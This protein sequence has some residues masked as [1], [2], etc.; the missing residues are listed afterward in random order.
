MLKHVC[1]LTRT[2]R[3]TVHNGKETHGAN[4]HSKEV[5][6]TLPSLPLFFFLALVFF[7]WFLQSSN[8][9]TTN[10]GVADR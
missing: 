5:M 6:T 8:I 7:L 3:L 4:S 9:M 10:G 2:Q 1:D